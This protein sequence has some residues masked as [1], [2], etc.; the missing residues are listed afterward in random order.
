MKIKTE[1]MKLKI[2]KKLLDDIALKNN[3]KKQKLLKKD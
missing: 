1:Y 3:L 2:N